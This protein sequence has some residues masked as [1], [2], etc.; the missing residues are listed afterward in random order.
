MPEAFDVAIVGYGPVGSVLAHLAGQQGLSVILID[1]ESDIYPLPRAVHFDGEGMRLFQTVGIAGDLAPMLYQN[2]GMRFVDADGSILIDW[3]RPQEVSEHGWFS[4]YR[5]HQP[6]LEV[7]LRAR[8]SEH[9]RQSIRL[10]S[11]VYKVEDSGSGVRLSIRDLS[12][13]E[14]SDV[15]AKYVVG[16][17]GANS[18]IRKEMGA[19][20]IDLRSDAEWIVVDVLM[21]HE[22]DDLSDYTIQ[23]CDPKRPTTIARGIG[24]RRRWEFMVMPG[25]DCRKL[26]DE[27]FL[28]GLLKPWISP[29]DAAIERSAVYRFKAVIATPWRKERLLIAGDAAHLTP[30]FLGQGLC[31]GIRDV[32]NLAW[33]LKWVIDGKASP[34]LLDTYETE[35]APHV[36]E[37]VSQAVRVGRILQCKTPVA[38]PGERQAREPELMTTPAPRLGPGLHREDDQAAG[39]MFPQPKTGEG[40]LLDDLV[41][42]NFAL[43]VDEREI[44]NLSAS[45]KSEYGR[46]GVKIVAVPPSALKSEKILAQLVRP[47]RYILASIPRDG[48]LADALQ[49]LPVA[50]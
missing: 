20:L 33:K 48:N 30:P 13:G 36:R 26:Q 46:L 6:D 29:R 47:D 49:L 35:R 24:G 10:L 9:K 42:Y 2:K 3:P 27:E 16:C 18:F 17:D 40:H 39:Y 31:A 21:K 50:Q 44:G 19:E 12:N 25:D 8:M 32:A 37:F 45:L 43:A 1:R 11:E 23:L 41:G 5:F 28:W 7:L 15:L 22:R 14:T 38:E 4:S 34:S